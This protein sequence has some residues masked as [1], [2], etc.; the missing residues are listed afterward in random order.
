MVTVSSWLNWFLSL[1]VTAVDWLGTIDVL[2]ISVLYF[3]IAIF[4]MGVVIRAV[5]YRA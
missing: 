3:L 2:G 4:I 5:L 1:I